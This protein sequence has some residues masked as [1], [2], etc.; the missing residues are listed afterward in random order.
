MKSHLRAGE[1]NLKGKKEM[2]LRCRCCTV[3][4]FRNHEVEKQTIKEI[5]DYDHDQQDQSNP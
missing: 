2:L 5:R 4:D 1:F 3:Q